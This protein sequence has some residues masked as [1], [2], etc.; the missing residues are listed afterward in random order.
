MKVKNLLVFLMSAALSSVSV[1]VL[2][3][4]EVDGICY[5]ILSEVGKTVEVTENPAGYSGDIVIPNQAIIEGESYMVTTIG[6]YAFEGCHKLTSIGLPAKLSDIG[7]YAFA[8]CTALAYMEIPENVQFIGMRAFSGCT[9]LTSVKIPDS[10]AGVNMGIFVFEDCT[11]LT[12]IELPNWVYALPNGT[13]SGCTGLASVSLPDGLH[14]IDDHA[15]S[16]CTALMSIELPASLTEIGMAAFQG[17]GLASVEIPDNVTLIEEG[18]FQECGNLASA[19]LPSGLETLGNFIFSKCGS[20]SSIE[21]PKSVTSIGIYA[22]FSCGSLTSIDIPENVTSIGDNVF[23]A[24]SSLAEIRSKNPTPPEV[25]EYTFEDYHYTDCVLTVPEG[26]IGNYGTAAVWCNF[27]NM[28]END[29]SGIGEVLDSENA[30]KVV[31]DDGRIMIKGVADN[32]VV[33]V[34]NTAGQV[35]YKGTDDIVEGLAG[36]MYI[37]VIGERSYKVAL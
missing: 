21:I 11:G 25:S 18:A 29:F 12:S 22:F 33:E 5:N 37:V 9:G 31:A 4:V 27:V 3:S 7:E 10:A 14:V 26:A 35:I 32:R 20:L 8:D 24:C 1:D 19:V 2:A 6:D 13:F 30:V 16:D 23:T 36:G 28:N 17:C 34:Y 15:F